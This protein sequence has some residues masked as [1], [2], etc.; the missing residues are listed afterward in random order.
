MQSEP[1]GLK[2][3]HLHSRKLPQDLLKEQPE[4]ANPLEQIQNLLQCELMALSC[5]GDVSYHM[6][7]RKQTD[8]NISAMAPERSESVV[9]SYV[10]S[11]L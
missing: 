9:Y 8:I 6:L 10:R 11:E 3:W 7:N 1:I 2:L 4:M 5:M